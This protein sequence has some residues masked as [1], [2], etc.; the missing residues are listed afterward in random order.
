MGGMAHLNLIY[1]LILYLK[2]KSILKLV[3]LL[4]GPH[5]FL[6]YQNLKHQS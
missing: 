5:L 6:V 3:L 1:N 2:P 4:V